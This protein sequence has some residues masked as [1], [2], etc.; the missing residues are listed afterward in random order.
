MAIF[1]GKI[2]ANLDSEGQLSGGF[3]QSP[4]RDLWFNGID[5]GDF[6]F[7]IGGQRIQL[8]QA[9]KWQPV[10]NGIRLLFRK[11]IADTGLSTSGLTALKFFK[12][13]YQMLVFTVRSTG[14]AQKAFFPFEEVEPIPESVLINPLTYRDLT[15]FRKVVFY[16]APPKDLESIDIK[17]YPD[18]DGNLALWEDSFIQDVI[19]QDF[20]DN[21][22]CIGKGQARKDQT[23]SAFNGLEAIKAYTHPELS[24]L[25]LYDAFCCKYRVNSL[26]PETD[27]DTDLELDP[28]QDNELKCTEDMRVLWELAKTKK[29]VILQGTAGVGKTYTTRELALRILGETQLASRDMVNQKYHQ[30]VK[31]GRI[32]FCTFHQSMD[33]EDFVEG[34]KPV[35]G[36]SGA[37]TFELMPGMF[38][39]I[40]QSCRDDKMRRNHVLIIDEINRGNLSKIFGELITLLE[41]DKREAAPNQEAETLSSKL[42]YSQD[43][44][45]VPH[46]IFIIGTMN[47]TDRSLGQIDYA[48]RRRFAF[49]TIKA[50]KDALLTFYE[51]K[52]GG[53]RS[54]ALNAF[55]EILGFFKLDQNVNAD[56][57][58]EDIMIGHSYFMASSSDVLKLKFEYELI[59]ILEEYRKDGVLT[60]SKEAFKAILDKIR[61]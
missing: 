19:V 28:N 30:A 17:L 22:Y 50:S 33:Y 16:P 5:V 18:S 40:C 32:A 59:P 2:N 29:Q 9:E 39:T 52:E 4:S 14:R 45:T 35:Q 7:V 26:Q 31:E 12:V 13:T 27:D 42:T 6:A 21:R 1:Y 15:N 49:Y 60:C 56:F 51:G 38:R 44:F 10:E 11:V 3:Y 53:P 23:L 47:T 58:V 41:I 25:R 55:E 24:L 20:T 48:L 46:N 36:K 8:W 57:D 54:K 43:D 37:P 34:Y 61:A